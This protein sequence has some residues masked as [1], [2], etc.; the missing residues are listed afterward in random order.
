MS[1]GFANSLRA[2]STVRLG[3]DGQESM[4]VRVQVAEV[5]DAVRVQA[6]PTEPLLAVK[7][8][9][10]EALYPQGEFHED[11]VMKLRGFEVLDEN[12]SLADSGAQD[13]STFLLAHRRRRPV[14][15]GTGAGRG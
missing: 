6:P 3:G 9:A 8:A 7:V 2:Q 4:T 15:S 13:G 14:R 1:A 5:W 11:F 10:L 12:A